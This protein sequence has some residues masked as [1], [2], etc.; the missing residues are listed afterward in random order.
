MRLRLRPL[1]AGRRN[2]AVQYIFAALAG[3]WALA[4]ALDFG[5]Q[6]VGL[7]AATAWATAAAVGALTLLL[8]VVPED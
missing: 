1:H 5:A 3:S 8:V 4:W 2:S 7:S 6:V